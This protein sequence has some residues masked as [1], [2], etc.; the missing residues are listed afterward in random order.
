MD[1]TLGALSRA[2]AWQDLI[3]E[4]RYSA[5]TISNGGR[6]MEILPGQLVGAISWLAKRWNWTPKTV[7]WWLDKLEIE[8]MISFSEKFK[9]RGNQNGKQAQIIT[10]CNYSEYQ[11]V[12]IQQRQTQ[13]H[14][15]GQQ[16]ANEGQTNGNIYKDNKG[17]K[18]QGNNTPASQEAGES[19]NISRPLESGAELSGEVLD[20]AW[21]IAGEISEKVKGPTKNANSRNRPRGELDGSHGITFAGGKL[22]VVNG[23]LASLQAEFPGIDFSSVCNKAAPA[24]AKL[25]YPTFEH[26]MATLRQYAQYAADDAAKRTPRGKLGGRAVDQILKS[27]SP[28]KQREYF[29]RMKGGGNA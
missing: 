17:T 28:E 26:A 7:R 5:G 24:L 27:L 20:A 9:E 1:G 4:C 15:N 8:G 23:T 25:S 3:M 2:E 29:A 12:E 22:T 10:V 6:K 21:K 18:E 13:G 19:I 14:T 16:T 11:K